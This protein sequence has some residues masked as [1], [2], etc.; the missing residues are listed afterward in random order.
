MTCFDRQ[1]KSYAF[2]DY[3]SAYVNAGNP[4]F[5]HVDRHIAGVSEIIGEA[6]E[7]NPVFCGNPNCSFNIRALDRD[8]IVCPG[9]GSP[10]WNRCGNRDC[11]ANNLM[12]VLKEGKGKMDPSRYPFECPVCKGELRTYWWKCPD[13]YHKKKNP[14]DK[15]SCPECLS[16][17]QLGLRAHK[18]IHRRPDLRDVECPGCIWL[19]PDGM[20]VR[21]PPSLRHFYENGVNGHDR[22]RFASRIKKYRDYLELT[23]HRCGNSVQEHYLFPTCPRDI[24]DDENRHHLY[25]NG[26]FFC[27]TR[28]PELHFYEC[29]HCGY[30]ILKNKDCRCGCPRCLRPVRKCYFCSDKYNMIYAPMEG[31]NPPRCPR[32][33]NSMEK[34]DSSD[35]ALISANL[36]A[37]AFCANIY[38]CVAGSNPWNTAAEYDLKHCQACPDDDTAAPLLPREDLVSIVEGCPLCSLVLSPIPKDGTVD[39]PSGQTLGH[40]FSKT[41]E[42]AG[43]LSKLCL[44]CG[45]RVGFLLLW[46][47]RDGFIPNGVHPKK[48]GAR[49]DSKST[50]ESKEL[51]PVLSKLSTKTE[52]DLPDTNF[53]DALEILTIL[54]DHLDDSTAFMALK[55]ALGIQDVLALKPIHFNRLVQVFPKGRVGKVMRMRLKGV[56]D[57][58]EKLKTRTLQWMEQ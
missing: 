41:A 13:H 2:R 52:G 31:S 40:K 45:L 8:A 50:D 34:R 44:I 16:E 39:Y 7:I 57:Q 20:R 4:V 32:C 5:F 18:D 53:H 24:D 37:P 56:L 23:A 29:Y 10:V 55:K 11:H 3:Y 12:E 17:Y 47:K 46:M 43:E 38:S 9:C 58:Q 1:R 33:T 30:P 51:M 42:E 21:V 22:L 28:H 35:G 15:E 26:D 14:S 25:R 27:C 48:K 54:R 6:I 49:K 19:D 36:N